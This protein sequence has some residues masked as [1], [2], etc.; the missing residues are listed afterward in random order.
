M[1]LLGT[2]TA[3][4]GAITGSRD[5]EFGGAENGALAVGLDGGTVAGAVIA[6]MLDWSPRRARVVM[7]GTIIGAFAGGMMSGLIA[8]PSDGE[9]R[10]A[11]GDIV[12]AAMTA[13]MWGGFGL[14]VMMTKGDNPDPRFTQP[15]KASAAGGA[16]TT[17]AP[18]IGRTGQ[19]GLMAG[20]SF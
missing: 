4:F 9:S 12:A 15:V 20:G 7:A 8:K 19:L 14:G 2:A 5:G 17:L 13:G 11:N 18:W 10:D 6:P 3:A 16:A 1:A